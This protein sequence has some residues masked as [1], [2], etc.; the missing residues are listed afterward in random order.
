VLK[1]SALS[2]T[3]S[4]NPL[5]TIT[6]TTNDLNVKTSSVSNGDESENNYIFCPKLSP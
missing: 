1:L 6:I 2:R 5:E 4:T 3:P